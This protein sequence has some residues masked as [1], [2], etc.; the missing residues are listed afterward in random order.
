MVRLSDAS[1]E[2]S[3]SP[4]P[5]E[6]DHALAALDRIRRRHAELLAARGGVPFPSAV[7][8]LAELRAERERDLP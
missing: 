2:R 4:T 8:V 3:P 7:E 5:E 6:R 1:Y